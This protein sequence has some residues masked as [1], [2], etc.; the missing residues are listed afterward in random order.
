MT[1]SPPSIPNDIIEKHDN[2]CDQRPMYYDKAVTVIVVFKYET[3]VLV[4]FLVSPIRKQG[5]ASFHEERNVRYTGSVQ[6]ILPF[7]AFLLNK[8]DLCTYDYKNATS[9][10]FTTGVPTNH[11]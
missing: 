2:S 5:H 10:N 4:Q 6:S 8:T 3:A 9:F 11:K 7:Y 1:V